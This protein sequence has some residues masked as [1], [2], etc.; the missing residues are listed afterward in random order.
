MN[1]ALDEVGEPELHVVPE[2]V[3][4]ELVVRAVGDVRAVGGVALGVAEVMLDGPDRQA[5]D[6]VDRAHPLRV[7]LGQ[8]IVDGDDVDALAVEGV[9]VG[10]QGRDERFPFS[11]LH[12]GDL[13]LV[14]DDPADDLDV[15][16]AHLGRP[17]GGLAD[18]GEGL[19]EDVAEGG[20]LGELLPEFRGFSQELG[21]G[22]RLDAGFEVVDGRDERLDL[23][24]GPFGVGPEELPENPLVH[25]LSFIRNPP[26]SQFAMRRLVGRLPESS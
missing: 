2:I 11:G 21:V 7:A 18:D 22:K 4:A 25:L 19:D 6:P 1:V 3:E 10:G 9:E 24:Q 12:L 20:A 23:L 16:V 5:E 13:A 17:P 14:E 8:V 26:G 15:E